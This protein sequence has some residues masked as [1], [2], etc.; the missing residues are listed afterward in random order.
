MCRRLAGQWRGRAGHKGYLW[1]RGREPA[2]SEGM[3]EETSEP[4]KTKACHEDVED[5]SF[6]GHDYRGKQDQVSAWQKTGLLTNFSSF[7]VW[8]RLEKGIT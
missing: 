8:S 3:A 6:N 4:R 2:S 7:L 5:V 1:R